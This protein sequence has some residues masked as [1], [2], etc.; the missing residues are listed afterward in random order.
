MAAERRKPVA[1]RR[2]VMTLMVAAGVAVLT[3]LAWAPHTVATT[4]VSDGLLRVGLGSG[5]TT[6]SL[7]PATC[8]GTI[9]TVIAYCYGDILAEGDPTGAL[10]PE[11]AESINADDA[12][13]WRFTLR[14]GV[15]F[16]DGRT[17]PP[18]DEIASINHHRGED[19]E[20]DAKSG[21]GTGGYVI[22]HSDPGVRIEVSRFANYVKSDRAPFE[23]VE[24][25]T[26]IDAAARQNAVMNGTV[27]VIDGAKA[28]ELWWHTA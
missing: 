9:H 4:P 28:S 19:V 1:A 14:A 10:A 13:S 12:Q 26:I 24:L 3:A 17:L 7:D 5:A 23:Q 8:E 11:L 22:G 6:D 16:Q 18:G 25:V 20:N 27:D 21:I 15:E 2:D